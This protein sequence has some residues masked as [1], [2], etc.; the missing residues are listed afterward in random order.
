[1]RSIYGQN[2]KSSVTKVRME[3]SIMEFSEL[4]E[5]RR[6]IRA[7]DPDKKVSKET[8]EELI[9]A[10]GKAPSWKNSQ[11]GRYYV[12]MSETM[13]SEIKS[14]CLAAFNARNCAD[15]PVLIV[16]AFV[17]S[18]SGFN[19]DGTPVNNLGE[20]WGAYD[21]GLQNENL[22]LKASE[23]GLDT[24]IMGIRD[25]EKLRE[26]LSVPENEEIAAVISVGYRAADPAAPKRKELSEIAKFF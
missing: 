1:M 20:G 9:K 2:S 18:I 26:K 22:V 12:I 15:A 17:K 24:L 4:L 7:Y 14:E 5:K 6:S 19:A 11:T 13:L 21:L 25:E 10:A 3:V 23:L 16:T 8:I